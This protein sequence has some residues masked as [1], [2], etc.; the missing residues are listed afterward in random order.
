MIV[1]SHLILSSN[2]APPAKRPPSPKEPHPDLQNEDEERNRLSAPPKSTANG[3][4]ATSGEVK[5]KK[6]GFKMKLGKVN[7]VNPSSFAALHI[8]AFFMTF[9]PYN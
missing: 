7:L 2:S 3:T 5:I 4:T 1:N 6:D 8:N 9:V